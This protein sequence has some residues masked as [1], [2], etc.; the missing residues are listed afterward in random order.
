[1]AA[2][3]EKS[4]LVQALLAGAGVAGVLVLLDLVGAFHLLELKTRDVRMKWTRPPKPATAGFDHPEIAVVMITDESIYWM[5]KESKKTWPW[6]REVFGFMFRA[7]ALGKARSILFDFFTHIDKD[8]WGTEGEWAKDI[9]RAP[10]SFLATQF[11]EDTDGEADWRKALEDLLKKYEIR[12]D[13]DRIVD[14]PSPYA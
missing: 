12:V 11:K 1:M 6:P 2:G 13:A 3:K 4:R 10:P 7:A 5:R 9:R 14:V 8:I